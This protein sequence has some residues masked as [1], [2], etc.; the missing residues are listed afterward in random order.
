MLVPPFLAENGARR[1]GVPDRVP[2]YV[3]FRVRPHV[4]VPTRIIFIDKYFTEGAMP[5]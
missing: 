3:V 1:F 4:G 5:K 2:G